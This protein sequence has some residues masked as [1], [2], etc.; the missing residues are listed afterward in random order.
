M[1]VDE[2]DD[3]ENGSTQQPKRV[4]DYGIEVDFDVL[5][6]EE[7]EVSGRTTCACLRIKPVLKTRF[8]IPPERRLPNSMRR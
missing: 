2:E 8:R 6:G 1:D 4:H 3:A 7:R 5:G